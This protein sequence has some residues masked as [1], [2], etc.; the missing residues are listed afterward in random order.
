MTDEAGKGFVRRVT[1]LDLANFAPLLR[2]LTKEPTARLS[3][4]NTS[5]DSPSG[6]NAN[7][8][9]AVQALF[10]GSKVQVNLPFTFPWGNLA[11]EPEPQS[12]ID[13]VEPP[14]TQND[15][16][17][18]LKDT[19]LVS[20]IPGPGRWSQASFSK[21]IF[22]EFFGAGQIHL[23]RI[24]ADGTVTDEIA[25]PIIKRSKNYCYELGAAAGLNYPP[26]TDGRPIGVF[27]RLGEQQF[28]YR[29]VMPS[30]PDHAILNGLLATYWEGGDR[31]M[32]RVT[33]DLQTLL[34]AWPTAPF[35]PIAFGT[36]DK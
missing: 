20:E 34:G 4:E 36:V 24:N 26:R 25:N 10:S 15:V 23:A 3:T 18:H 6:S 11:P 19:V 31:F 17:I 21:K 33:I 27:L 8:F 30:D 5:S 22:D 13:A 9:V 28:Q 7:E 12:S 1:K 14:D 29:L 2:D 32:R 35:L 16:L